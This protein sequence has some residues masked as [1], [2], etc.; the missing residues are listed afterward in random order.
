MGTVHFELQ[1]W[2][3]HRSPTSTQHY[4]RITPKTPT[5]AYTQAGY[6]SRNLRTIEVLVGRDAVASGAVAGGEP[7]QHYDLGHDYCTYSLFERCQHRMACA[8][9]DFYRPK[10]SAQAQLIEAKATC[11]GCSSPSR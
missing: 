8:R 11:S 2:L 4:A 10:D 1:A 7:W 6:F 3:G 5:R 9:C